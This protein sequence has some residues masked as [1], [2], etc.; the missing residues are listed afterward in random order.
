M[1]DL[2]TAARLLDAAQDEA[3]DIGVPMCMA[4]VDDGAN[5]VAF[6]RM[7]DALIGSIDIARNKAY[8]AVALQAPTSAIGEAAQ[9]GAELYGIETTNDGRIV[10]F[11]GGFP[12]ERDGDIV[13]GIGVSGGAVEEDETVASAGVDAFEG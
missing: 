3:T 4:V 2:D 7:D 10:S 5:L 9:P 8:T 12:L 11:G 6:R 1:V 13:G